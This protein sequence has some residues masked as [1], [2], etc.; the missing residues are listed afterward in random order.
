MRP[1]HLGKLNKIRLAGLSTLLLV[2]KRPALERPT[3]QID[4][5]HAR[6][7]QQHTQL[8]TILRRRPL[9]LKLDTVNLH[10]HDKPW[11]RHPPFDLA[12]HLK[13]NPAPTLQTLRPVLVRA[14]IRRRREELREQVA[15]RAV[16]LDAVVAGE[17]AQVSRLAEAVDDFAYAFFG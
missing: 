4:K 14:P 10:T 12:N 2:L 17:M 1:D 3:T 16:D 11:I 13:N 6:L 15:V 5:I 8:F 9:I 7:L